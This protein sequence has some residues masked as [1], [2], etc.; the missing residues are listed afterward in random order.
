MM[1]VYDVVRAI[2]VSVHIHVSHDNVITFLLI[3][4]MTDCNCSM[5]QCIDP[6]CLDNWRCVVV[7]LKGLVSVVR[8]LSYYMY[9][10][11]ELSLTCDTLSH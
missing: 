8:W 5:F 9:K 3:V 10:S 4:F 2:A 1:T 7:V 6:N 11:I